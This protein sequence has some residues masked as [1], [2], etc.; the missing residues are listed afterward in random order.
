MKKKKISGTAAVILFSMVTGG[1]CGYLMISQLA[2]LLDS[3]HGGPVTAA[4]IMAGLVLGVYL[5][6]FLHIAAHEAGHLIGGLLTGYR[7]ASFRLGSLQLTRQNGRL[8]WRLLHIAGT[9]G[10]CLMAPPEMTDG[11]FPVFAYNLGGPVMN[12]LLSAIC[13]LISLPLW[14]TA[15]AAILL[16][17]AVL[18]LFLGL[19]NG[20]P[21]RMNGVDNDGYNARSL[22]KNPAAMRAFWIQMQMAHQIAQGVRLKDMPADWFAPNPPEQM[23]NNLIA[24]L[25]A[26]ACNRLLDQGQIRD[27]AEAID[28]LL[29]QPTG[30][31]GLHRNLLLC[32]RL[33]CELVRDNNPD[34]VARLYTKDLQKFMRSMKQYPT[35]LRTRYA[36]ALL[37]HR[38]AD[39]AAKLL[40]QF[41]RT[42]AHHPYSCEIEGE[43]ELL[44]LVKTD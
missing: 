24:T 17:A 3:I 23:Q 40:T 37:H 42:A 7:F 44:A 10:Q 12:L 16:A 4:L 9:G 13:I 15:A 30:I 27:T 19:I 25:S 21:M 33:F 5:L 18:G 20:I 8:Q 11:V 31:L 26:F 6:V 39:T 2:P 29:A 14:G 32:D 41:E 36:L 34:T 35:V 22:K 28:T 1:L 43:R 38:D